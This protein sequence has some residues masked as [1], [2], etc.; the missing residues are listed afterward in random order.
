M[1][2]WKQVSS[3]PIGCRKRDLSGMAGMPDTGTSDA[4]E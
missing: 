1:E 4:T 3:E 2:G